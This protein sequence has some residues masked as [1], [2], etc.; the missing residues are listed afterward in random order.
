MRVMSLGKPIPSFDD[1]P[2]FA[3]DVKYRMLV[4]EDDAELVR[5]A[6][7]T[8]QPGGRTKW[9]HHG[10]DQV[11]IITGGHGRVGTREESFDVRA[12]DVVLIPRGEVHFHGAT[13]DTVLTHISVLTPGEEV[14]DE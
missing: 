9:H 11:L 12:G 3:G 8:F 6:E 2:V 1:D 10:C 14:I 5:A 13:D 4:S 7:V